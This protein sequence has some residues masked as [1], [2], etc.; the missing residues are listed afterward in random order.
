MFN[1]DINPK[2]K[3]RRKNKLGSKSERQTSVDKRFWRNERI[4][5][6]NFAGN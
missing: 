4:A 6:Q 2:P 3:S 5:Y 1:I